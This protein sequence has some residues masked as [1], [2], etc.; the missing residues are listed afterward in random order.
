MHPMMGYVRPFSSPRQSP[1]IKKAAQGCF[2]HEDGEDVRHITSKYGNL[3]ASTTVKSA[4]HVLNR[5]EA[6][7]RLSMT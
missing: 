4:G 5:V 3:K 6:Q 2:S 1:G 7:K